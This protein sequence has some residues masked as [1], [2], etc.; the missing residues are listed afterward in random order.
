MKIVA[1][2]LLVVAVLGAWFGAYAFLHFKTPLERIHAVTFTNIVT[3]GAIMLA[4][5][6]AKGITSQTLKC[7]FIF[8]IT[9]L[10][11]ALLSHAI[12]RAIHFRGGVQR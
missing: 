3:L 4:G 7:G 11:G 2:S 9:A 1:E 12:G 6:C 8:I 10:F 5:F